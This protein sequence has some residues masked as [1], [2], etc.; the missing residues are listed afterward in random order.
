MQ[1][2]INPFTDK[3]TFFLHFSNSDTIMWLKL[4]RTAH[5]ENVFTFFPLKYRSVPMNAILR[6]HII[7]NYQ[8]VRLSFVKSHHFEGYLFIWTYIPIL[9]GTYVPFVVG[10][11]F[12]VQL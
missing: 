3:S 6:E 4:A 5:V 9:C 7:I 11:D 1:L 8:S 2:F 10:S 12:Y